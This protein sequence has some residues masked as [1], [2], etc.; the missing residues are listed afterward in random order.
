MQI[1]I[2]GGGPAAVAAA[3]SIRVYD[4]HSRII[5]FSA[6]KILPYRRPLLISKLNNPVPDERFFIHDQHFYDR[7]NIEIKLNSRVIAID[8]PENCIVLSDQTRCSYDS[9]LLAYGASAKKTA[10]QLPA[11]VF[12]LHDSEDVPPVRAML[13]KARSATVIGGG[14]LGLET[15]GSCLQLNKKTTLI[16][17]SSE[18]MHGILDCE[19]GNFLHEQLLARNPDLQIITNCDLTA[20]HESAAGQ[21]N[22]IFASGTTDRMSVENVILALGFQ[23]SPPGWQPPV[24]N[25]KLEVDR[26]MKLKG[27]ENIFAAGDCAFYPQIPSGSYRNAVQM[28]RI[29]GA[30]IAG[31]Q[32]FIRI[33][34][35]EMRGSFMD[36]KLYCAGEILSDDLEFAVHIK[37]GFLRKLYYRNQQLV[38]CVL[39][40]DVSGSSEFYHA[41]SANWRCI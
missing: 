25:C 41:I 14:I 23:T 10:G 26:F 31:E 8:W 27:F 2:V 15:A 13:T 4:R 7:N 9:L 36:F 35:R 19:C 40:G 24:K 34:P 38:G 29:A 18:I 30:N 6:E 22:C 5:I 28:G 1:I 11:N 17:R 16:E 39:L 12:T 3:E 33:P 32:E 37:Q 21:I 20:L